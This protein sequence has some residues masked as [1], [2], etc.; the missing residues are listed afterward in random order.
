MNQFHQTRMG[1]DFFDHFVPKI[2]DSLNEINQELAKANKLKERE[3]ELREKELEM[4]HA[5]HQFETN[6]E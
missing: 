5:E 3:L 1:Q 2:A 6:T 4:K